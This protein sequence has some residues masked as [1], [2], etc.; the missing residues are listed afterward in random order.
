MTWVA[1]ALLA[2]LVAVRQGDPW[3]QIWSEL[4]TLRGGAV[5]EAEAVVLR[6]HLNHASRE[7]SDEPRLLLLRAA[8]ES[9]EGG[10][11]SAIAR[12]LA[13]M[14]P[15]PFT[16]REEWFLADLL[17]PGR[18]RAASV[19]VALKAPGTLARWQ[20]LLAWSTA[21]DEARA[22]RYE[23]STLPI[24]RNLHARYQ[25]EWS[26]LDLTVTLKALGNYE[27]A[28]HTL[29]EVIDSE[30]AVGRHPNKLW[31]QLGILALGFGDEGRARDYLGKALALGSDDAGLL[32]SRLD[33]IQGRTAAARRGFRALLRN[34]PPPDWAWRGWGA[35][36]LPSA[37]ATP[38]AKNVPNS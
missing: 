10:E 38:V 16:A 31:E 20:V 30:A 24:Q 32:L 36:L 33:L 25:A 26:A 3:A 28:E 2:A 7:D 12:R 19:L 4:E 22:L 18:E 6:K 13:A 1:L 15:S 17:P 8:L 34:Q 29:R 5:A 14:E 9:L 27:T 37:F 23:E 35:A 21:V 11:L